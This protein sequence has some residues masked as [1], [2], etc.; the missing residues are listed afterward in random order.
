MQF[1]PFRAILPTKVKGVGCA[2]YNVQGSGEEIN[3]WQEVW[4]YLYNTSTPSWTYNNGRTNS[5]RIFDDYKVITQYMALNGCLP[6]Q[7]R[8]K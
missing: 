1:W 4:D 2:H 3:L 5:D 8:L 7:I 6:K